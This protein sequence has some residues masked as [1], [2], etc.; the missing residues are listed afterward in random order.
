MSDD[1]TA[2]GGE[3]NETRNWEEILVEC[4]EKQ[5]YKLDA[6]QKTLVEAIVSTKYRDKNI[7]AEACAGSGKTSTLSVA[8]HIAAQLGVRALFLTFTREGRKQI[9]TK[10]K[11]IGNYDE[12]DET[13]QTKDGEGED[14]EGGEEGAKECK[15]ADLEGDNPCVRTFH[16]FSGSIVDIKNQIEEGGSDEE[17]EEGEEEK[18][19]EGEPT[20]K[21]RLDEWSVSPYE[22]SLIESREWLS[23]Q[24]PLLE[25][26][27]MN[28]DLLIIDEVQDTSD[29]QW[30][31]VKLVRRWFNDCRL[32]MVGDRYQNIFNYAG[33]NCHPFLQ[34]EE[35]FKDREWERFWLMTNYRTTPQNCA[36]LTRFLRLRYGDEQIRTIKSGR[37]IMEA[38]HNDSQSGNVDATFGTFVD[39]AEPILFGAKTMRDAVQYLNK[40][41]RAARRK[42]RR[43]W[44]LC[45]TTALSNRIQALLLH[46]LRDLED[47]EWGIVQHALD[48]NAAV[49]IDTCHKSKGGEQDVV[50]VVG[51]EE[52]YF[53]IGSAQTPSVVTDE[54][55]L[56]YVACSRA[57]DRL[58]LL[59]IEADRNPVSRFLGKSAN[60][61]VDQETEILRVRSSDPNGLRFSDE[62]NLD[63][64]YSM[65]PVVSSHQIATRVNH[66]LLTELCVD[67]NIDVQKIRL[68]REDDAT[69]DLPSSKKWLFQDDDADTVETIQDMDRNVSLVLLHAFRRGMI[70]TIVRWI[71]SVMVKRPFRNDTVE[72]ILL[73][74][75]VKRD[76]LIANKENQRLSRLESMLECLGSDGKAKGMRRRIGELALDMGWSIFEWEQQVRSRWPGRVCRGYQEFADNWVVGMER[77]HGSDMRKAVRHLQMTKA[78]PGSAPKDKEEKDGDKDVHMTRLEE[79][80][81]IRGLLRSML[82]VTIA[83]QRFSGVAMCTALRRNLLE[84]DTWIDQYEE[85]WPRVFD[86]VNRTIIHRFLTKSM[87]E[88]PKIDKSVEA[89]YKDRALK[90]CANIHLE[91]DDEEEEVEGSELIPMLPSH[92]EMSGNGELLWNGAWIHIESDEHCSPV[93][94][95]SSLLQLCVRNL[96]GDVVGGTICE[97]WCPMN[98]SLYRFSLAKCERSDV[99]RCIKLA[100]VA[101]VQQRLPG[102]PL[103]QDNLSL[104]SAR[105][106]RASTLAKD[107]SSEQ[108]IEPIREKREVVQL[109]S[110][111]VVKERERERTTTSSTSTSSAGTKSMG[112]R[113]RKESA[114]IEYGIIKKSKRDEAVAQAAQ[115]THSIF[116]YFKPRSSSPHPSS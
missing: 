27:D 89:F 68:T 82:W 115:G 64:P 5:G 21:S 36:H 75:Y 96:G 25:D 13:T 10:C 39:P 71:L 45:R 79:S 78:L 81:E 33:A 57:I 55:N 30:E 110:K 35:C 92:F 88:V 94:A 97:I 11:R 84:M 54:H 85:L 12:P 42:K 73:L 65:L 70:R 112:S 66:D 100:L 17:D 46:A 24:E 104:Q 108:M 103:A 74:P 9:V 95:V 86:Y 60:V 67:C 51:V 113:K 93:A 83:E 80:Q 50:V 16:S 102:V 69:D 72:Q 107:C 116:S 52:S 77:L 98:D 34:P 63:P 99:E 59:V 15:L 47:D 31:L 41:V 22:R 32:V 111:S 62:S 18:K 58:H 105:E 106:E 37:A 23:E 43:V 20:L 90:I 101:F 3:G 109:A 26:D 19:E 48:K 8:V 87:N 4:E 29:E 114:P 61:W 91:C 49:C 38:E 2:E 76:I 44:M 28:R 7:V 56:L 40:V 14:G 53:P 1:V 6:E